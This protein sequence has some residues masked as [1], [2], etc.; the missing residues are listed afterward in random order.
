MFQGKKNG[1]RQYQQLNVKIKTTGVKKIRNRHRL[2]GKQAFSWGQSTETHVQK[3][4]IYLFIS[5]IHLFPSTHQL[6]SSLVTLLF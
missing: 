2:K 3:A 1:T 5:Q 6:Y 4:S